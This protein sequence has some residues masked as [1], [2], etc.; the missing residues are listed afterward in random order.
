MNG[1]DRI[2]VRDHLWDPFPT[3]GSTPCQID[4]SSLGS[5]VKQRPQHQEPDGPAKRSHPDAD[6]LSVSDKQG[7]CTDAVGLRYL[8][9]TDFKSRDAS[10]RFFIVQLKPRPGRPVAH[11]GRP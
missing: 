10:N 2:F 4:I 8:K 5:T 6:P 3:H 7:P 1:A 11:G 9:A